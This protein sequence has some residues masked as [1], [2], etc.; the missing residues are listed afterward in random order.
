MKSLLPPINLGWNHVRARCASPS[1]H[2]KLLMRPVPTKSAGIRIGQDWYCGVDCFVAGARFP[3]A[4]L[5]ARRLMEM[6]RNPRLSLG[7]ALLSKDLLTEDQLRLATEVSQKNGVDLEETLLVLGLTNE[8]HLAAA[9]SVQW[10]YPVLN[11][12]R[13]GR[14][15]EV[16]IP[17]TLLRSFSAAP[18]FYSAGTKRLVLGFVER[19]DHHLLQS[20]EQVTGYRAE[21]CFLTAAEFSEQMQ[22][23][24]L[25]VFYEEVVLEEP[26]DPG[27]MARALGRY[28]L[29]AA[30]TDAAFVQ[31]KSWVW[32]RLTGKRRIVDVLFARANASRTPKNPGTKFAP[33]IVGA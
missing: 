32:A 22:R 15:V 29:D 18:L 26:G 23:V 2:N 20:I 19:V 9:R 4:A 8:K 12:E 1:C 25:P 28:A 21:P 13:A 17:L 27:Q 16:E 33:R 10:G 30:A 7:L 5:S 24:V 3:L 14:M 11:Q 31:C 6:P